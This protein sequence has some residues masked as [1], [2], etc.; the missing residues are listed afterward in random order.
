MNESAK[1][2]LVTISILVLLGVILFLM[3]QKNKTAEFPCEAC[4]EMSEC[5][6]ECTSYCMK[7]F[8]FY[9]ETNAQSNGTITCQCNCKNPLTAFK[10]TP[11]Q[12]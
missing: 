3:F 8:L 7:N 1:K 11:T 12:Q 2:V 4:Q 5:R 6:G 10:S 9:V